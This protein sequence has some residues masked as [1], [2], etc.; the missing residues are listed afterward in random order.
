MALAAHSSAGEAHRGEEKN[1]RSH[2]C[3]GAEVLTV[4][5]GVVTDTRDGIQENEPGSGKPA[6]EL[7]LDTVT[8]IVWCWT[9]G[10]GNS[11]TT[12]TCSRGVCAF[13]RENGS[14][15]ILK[16]D[17]LPYVFDRFMR[18]GKRVRNEI[19]RD[20]WA[21]DFRPYT[22]RLSNVGAAPRGAPVVRP[23]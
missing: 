12:R 6:A 17:G 9:S 19:P 23:Q 14:A 20:R 10:A 18:E 2:F 5:D 3:Y 4:A 13:T 21:V 22:F 11:R 8:G 15:E 7:T 16:G 1:N